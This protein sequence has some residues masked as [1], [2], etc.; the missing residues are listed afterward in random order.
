MRNSKSQSVSSFADS[1]FKFSTGID[2]FIGTLKTEFS[3]VSRDSPVQCY[4]EKQILCK[5]FCSWHLME[6]FSEWCTTLCTAGNLNLKTP[7][8]IT[9]W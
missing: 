8:L 6:W 3:H 7:G 9:E 5:N 2:I 4:P 1:V